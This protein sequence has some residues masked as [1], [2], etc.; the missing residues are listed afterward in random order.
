[1][2]APD[3]GKGKIIPGC[4]YSPKMW[5]SGGRKKKKEQKSRKLYG[6]FAHVKPEILQGTF[7]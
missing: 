2:N 5:E 3:R 6:M 7:E 4:F 1:M